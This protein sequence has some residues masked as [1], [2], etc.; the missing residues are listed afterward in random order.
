[1]VSFE[2]IEAGD[3]DHDSFR[4]VDPRGYVEGGRRVLDAALNGGLP[5]LPIQYSMFL[6]EAPMVAG[7]GSWRSGKTA[8]GA[9]S[10]V[11]TAARNPWR[12][13][14]QHDHP[15]SLVIS[16]TKKILRDSTMRELKRL[17]PR[18]LILREWTHP[19]LRL[20]LVNG[21]DLIFMPWIGKIQGESAC[22][23][24]LD[25][26]HLLSGA[27][28]AEAMFTNFMLRATDTRAIGGA[29]VVVTGLPQYG[30]LSERF[31]NPSSPDVRTYLASLKDNFY[32]DPT[33]I[34]LLYASTTEEEAVTTIEGRW[35]R[36]IEAIFYKFSD[37]NL[38]DH[39]GDPSA[40][41]DLTMDL[42]DKSILLAVQRI[43]VMT[44]T[45]SGLS[46][47]AD[48]LLVVDEFLGENLSARELAAAW[49]A[50]PGRKWRVDSDSLICI[51]PKADRDQIREIAEAFGTDEP[52][53]PTI[54]R[55]NPKR[56]GYYREFGFRCVNAALCD[57]SG[58]R[59]LYLSR[60]NLGRAAR[61]VV[62]CLR[63]FKRKPNGEPK[64]D[65]VLDHGADAIRYIT[66]ARLGLP[67]DA[68]AR[69]AEE[70]EAKAA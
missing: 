63:G 65:N 69:R 59:R 9:L 53:G 43:R 15:F 2:R 55:S 4:T 29:K 38:I 52:N 25:E 67:A 37:A 18:D 3:E 32:L 42:G 10:T 1:M 40:P 19:N 56:D 45:P 46:L 28:G 12:P 21:H 16:E 49:K 31:D 70:A 57:L 6:D 35:R 51:D 64:R 68:L 41:V 13:I 20:R 27:S 14:Y 61:G 8:G 11:R 54:K 7:L 48:G 60:R 17:L 23:V 66:V 58:N 24:W 33:V 30:W 36:P 62:N 44:T 26:A 34:D 5:L 50:G 39:P 47:P 22:G